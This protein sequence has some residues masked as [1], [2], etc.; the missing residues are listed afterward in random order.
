MPTDG[1]SRR[2]LS[3]TMGIGAMLDLTGATIFRVIRP[4]LPDPPPPGS[5]PDPFRAAM[6]TIMA[7]HHQVVA[8]APDQSI[9]AARREVVTHTPDESAVTLPA[10][11]R[12]T[13]SQGPGASPTR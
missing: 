9:A 7:A 4:T 13:V 5:R 2:V 10:W 1:S 12:P 11:P 8:G 3:V 6:D